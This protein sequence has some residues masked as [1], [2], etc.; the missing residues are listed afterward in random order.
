MAQD[1]VGEDKV[2]LTHEFLAI[3]LRVR[4]PG[5]TAALGNFE[6][7][8]LVSGR[9]GVITILDRDGI[10]IQANGYYGVAKAEWRR[11]FAVT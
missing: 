4:R 1:R 9:R 11:M 8:G 3:M 5:V 10:E 2:A 6:R 7:R